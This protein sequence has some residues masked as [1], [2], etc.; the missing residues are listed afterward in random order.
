MDM[1]EHLLKSLNFNKVGDSF[2]LKNLTDNILSI[3]IMMSSAPSNIDEDHWYYDNL[4]RHLDE[5]KSYLS[6]ESITI[7]DFEKNR[8]Y[9]DILNINIIYDS[10]NSEYTMPFE[11]NFDK[12]FSEVLRENRDKKI[13]KLLK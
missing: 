2:I 5:T 11:K 10:G 12:I 1:Y 8:L 3:Q 13:N 4:K 9:H 7:K 6:I